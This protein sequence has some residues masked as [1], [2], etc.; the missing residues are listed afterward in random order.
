MALLRAHVIGDLALSGLPLRDELLHP[1]TTSPGAAQAA[2][3]AAEAD[4]QT[5]VDY[6]ERSLRQWDARETF[7]YAMVDLTDDAIAGSCGLMSRVEP[8]ARLERFVVYY[9]GTIAKMQRAGTRVDQIDLRYRNGFAAR[10][11]GFRDAPASKA[12][13]ERR[14]GRH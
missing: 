12:A 7:Q 9:P 5:S 13:P 14:Q 2:I 6:L 4:R 1:E 11:P 3:L 10:V 8:G